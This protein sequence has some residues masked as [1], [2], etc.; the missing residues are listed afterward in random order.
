[1]CVR[2]EGEGEGVTVRIER[3]KEEKRNVARSR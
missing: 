2:G 3:R 1:M